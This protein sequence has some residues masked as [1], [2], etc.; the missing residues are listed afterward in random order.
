MDMWGC[1][2]EEYDTVCEQALL[3]MQQPDFRAILEL[4]TAW[5]IKR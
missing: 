1:A 4:L 3:E 2:T 5:S